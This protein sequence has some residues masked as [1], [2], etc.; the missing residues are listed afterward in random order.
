MGNNGSRFLLITIPIENHNE[1]SDV[2][3]NGVNYFTL[4]M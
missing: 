4:K 3:Q 2:E 1:I